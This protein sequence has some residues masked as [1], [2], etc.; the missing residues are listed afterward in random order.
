MNRKLVTLA[1]SYAV[2][3]TLTPAVSSADDE[4]EFGLGIYGDFPGISGKTRFPLAGGHGFEIGI[5]TILDNLKFTFQGNFEAREGRWGL[6]TDLIYLDVSNS[7]SN[8][9]KGMVGGP[10]NPSR[11]LISTALKSALHSAGRRLSAK[12]ELA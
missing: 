5:D 6:F 4:W 8:Y 7:R 1:L 9:C 10:G 11:I 3:L 2:A 12:S